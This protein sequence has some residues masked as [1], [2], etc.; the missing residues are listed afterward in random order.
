MGKGRT[1][2]VSDSDVQIYWVVADMRGPHRVN[3][4]SQDVFESY[5]AAQAECKNRGQ[6]YTPLVLNPQEVLRG[7]VEENLRLREE[8][9]RLRVAVDTADDF[10]NRPR[11]RRDYA[12]EDLY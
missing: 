4:A 10:Q 9:Q 1:Q 3:D 11:G 6:G 12:D 5:S 7:L 8:N 2:P